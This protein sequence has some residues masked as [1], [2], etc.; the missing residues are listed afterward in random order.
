MKT[1]ALLASVCA[2]VVIRD[3]PP[4]H[5]MNQTTPKGVLPMK[6]IT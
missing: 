2:A 6:P 4:M 1:L 3:D 5:W